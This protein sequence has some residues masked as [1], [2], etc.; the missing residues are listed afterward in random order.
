MLFIT[1]VTA[2][3]PLLI[4][5]YYTSPLSLSPR[6]KHISLCPQYEQSHWP[7]IYYLATPST[8]TI[9][10]CL[11]YGLISFYFCPDVSAN[12]NFLLFSLDKYF[13]YAIANSIVLLMPNLRSKCSNSYNLPSCSV[14]TP[15]LSQSNTNFKLMHLQLLVSIVCSII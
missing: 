14:T 5:C 8:L 4:S 2:V 7:S 1:Y 6:K 10:Q 13:C 3:L 9:Q 15:T 12:L 11:W